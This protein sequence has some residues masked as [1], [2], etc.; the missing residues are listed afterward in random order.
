MAKAPFIRSASD[1]AELLVDFWII[2]TIYML[3]RR[4][5]GVEI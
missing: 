1:R 5:L 3:P 4:L 2:T